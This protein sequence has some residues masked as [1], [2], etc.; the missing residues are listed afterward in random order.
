MIDV[1][2]LESVEGPEH[3]SVAAEVVEM[4]AGVG[5]TAEPTP[6]TAGLTLQTAEPRLQTTELALITMKTVMN[7]EGD[8]HN[9]QYAMGFTN[10]Q[11][12]AILAKQWD[13]L[14]IVV[15]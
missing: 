14:E 8:T 9:V 7:V 1:T 4:T 11:R 13:T 6:Q 2:I 5:V 3:L 15:P 12:N 10:A